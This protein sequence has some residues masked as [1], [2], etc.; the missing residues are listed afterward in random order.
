LQA[1]TIRCND[2]N[3]VQ[4]SIPPS[5]AAEI[6]VANAENGVF[7]TQ[8]F[9]TPQQDYFYSLTPDVNL[10]LGFWAATAQVPQIT[11]R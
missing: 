9:P 7:P 3:I 5:V 6:A 2:N 10:G 8:F 4:D 1:T 11:K